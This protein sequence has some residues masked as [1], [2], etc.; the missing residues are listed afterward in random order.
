MIK[1]LSIFNF[2]GLNLRIHLMKKVLFLSILVVILVLMNSWMD[3]GGMRQCRLQYNEAFHPKVNANMVILGA[4][5]AAHG[6]NPKYLERDGL[7]VF[8]F[9][10]DGAGPIFFLKWYRKIFQRYYRNPDYVIYGVHWVMFG[11]KGLQRQFEQDSTYFPS[12]FL[13]NEFYDFV[14]F[15]EFYHLITFSGFHNLK[16][17]NT[18]ML[19]RFAFVRERKGLPY[20]LLRTGKHSNPY[21][22][23]KYYHGFVPYERK[24]V[25]DKKKSWKPQNREDRIRGFEEL[26]DDFK[27][28]K[29][30]VIFVH[31]PGYLPARDDADISESIQLIHK[32][33]EERDIPFLDYETE[34]V[35]AIN[36]DPSMFSDWIHLNEKGSEAFSKLLES[37][38]E[39]LL[40]ER[41]VKVEAPRDQNG[42]SDGKKSPMG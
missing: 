29:T 17:L 25:M 20:R 1:L 31:I 2:R 19:N 10:Q 22:L 41:P 28:K 26:L 35:T 11:S 4:S 36:T 7:R 3:R 5:H 27:R 39:L 40:K 32:I 34:R 23:S 15:K 21:V 33:A 18:L 8:N 9:S 38:L 6:I 13:F 14:T 16:T 24:G 12:Q 42:L 37:D 30:Q